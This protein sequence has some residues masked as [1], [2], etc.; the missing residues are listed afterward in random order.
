MCSGM[1]LAKTEAREMVPG[2]LIRLKLKFGFCH[3]NFLY[4][5]DSIC[6]QLKANPQFWIILYI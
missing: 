3:V 1:L 6:T 2:H 4:W 5:T